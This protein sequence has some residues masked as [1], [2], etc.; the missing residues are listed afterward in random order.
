MTRILIAG[1]YG[2]GNIGDE[3]ILSGIISSI[4]KHIENPCFSVITNDPTGTLKLHAVN[5]VSQSFNR[6]MVSFIKN[7]FVEQEFFNV[8]TAID[9]CDVFVLGGG[10]LLQD[11]KIHYL[12]I[13]LSL[14]K[15]AQIKGKTTVIYG[16]GAGPIDTKLGK[17][18][19]R[20][21]LN[22]VDLVTV[23]DDKS[24]VALENCGLRNVTQTADPAFAVE[25][26][27]K[28]ELSELLNQSGINP[29]DRFIGATFC[30]LLYN[31]DAYRKTNGPT[32][33][34][35][36]RQALL[37]SVFD[38]LARVYPQDLLYYPTVHADYTRCLQIR[39]LMKRIDRVTV[40]S[41]DS[42]FKRVLAFTSSLDM[43]IGMRLHSL[44]ISSIM[45]VPFVP[46]SYSSKVQSFLDLFGLNKFYIDIEE[47][48]QADF[49]E[50]FFSNISEVWKNKTYYSEILSDVTAKLRSKALT[51]G[52]LVSELLK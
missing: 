2:L 18:L 38:E 22:K 51:N 47:I 4:K 39:N 50:R 31:D 3:L 32:F 17:Y 27:S 8:A 19:C 48:E 24:R 9:S 43:L 13:L 30:N 42:N 23:R 10:E 12:P 25:K 34:W 49:K 7:Q 52:R 29:E 5:P 6:G 14:V 44:I 1:Y 45:G 35:T 20:E 21:V 16:I 26:P 41:P 46:L 28:Q 40:M 33:D 36:R 11:L 15:A 37:A